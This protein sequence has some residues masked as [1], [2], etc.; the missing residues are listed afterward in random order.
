MQAVALLVATGLGIASYLGLALLLKVE[1][2]DFLRKLVGDRFGSPQA[3]SHSE[4]S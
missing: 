2:I 4:S 3:G 1:E